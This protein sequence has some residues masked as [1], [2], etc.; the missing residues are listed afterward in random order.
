MFHAY[1]RMH[2]LGHA[3]SIEA[4]RDSRLVGGL[5]G[6]AIGRVFF[7]E[8][9]FHRERDAS[10]IVFVHLA[11]QLGYW[12]YA[13]LDCQLSSTHLSSLGAVN[14]PRHQFTQLLNRLCS[15]PSAG[16]A[17]QETTDGSGA[18]R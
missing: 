3:H 11:R 6:M 2:E 7:G 15:E 17:W 1:C 10:K 8:S 5:Y 4:W 14:L 16:S 9:M 13:L 18:A 12:Q